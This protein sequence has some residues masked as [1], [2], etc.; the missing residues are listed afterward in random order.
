[1]GYINGILIHPDKYIPRLPLFHELN[2]SVV[3]EGVEIEDISVEEVVCGG[4]VVTGGFVE[5]C[6]EVELG[7]VDARV[8]VEPGLVGGCDVDVECVLDNACDVNVELG[9]VDD[10]DVDVECVL[11]NACDANVELGLVADCDV[12]F[13]CVLDNACDVNVELGLVDDCDVDCLKV[14]V[15]SGSLVVVCTSFTVDGEDVVVSILSEEVKLPV[16]GSK[17]EFGAK[18]E[19]GVVN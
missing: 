5:P 11:D 12:D 6:V 16:V 15:T 7:L 18:L 13:E 4:V 2:G 19:V 14:D 1:M 3:V 9:L 8:D 10:C 17:V